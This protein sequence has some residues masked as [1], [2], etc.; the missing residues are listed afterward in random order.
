MQSVVFGLL[1]VAFGWLNGNET[2]QMKQSVERVVP[3]RKDK[4]KGERLCWGTSAEIELSV[5]A[6]L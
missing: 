5:E 6:E 2:E 4:S 3:L 1:M